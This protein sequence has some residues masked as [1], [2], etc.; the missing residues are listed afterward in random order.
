[1]FSIA[2]KVWSL[3]S[4]C[5]TI[6]AWQVKTRCVRLA[7][8][9][10]VSRR[11]RVLVACPITGVKA[12]AMSIALVAG[13]IVGFFTGRASKAAAR[14]ARVRLTS[15]A[16]AAATALAAYLSLENIALRPLVGTHAEPKQSVL[17]CRA[18]RR[19]AGQCFVL[20]TDAVFIL[21]L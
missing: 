12:A 21:L 14:R 10:Q 11:G 5:K 9:R 15:K 17:R 13:V 2:S 3:R 1:M 4:A 19:S 6:R 16:A 18:A 20:C 7:A 8:L